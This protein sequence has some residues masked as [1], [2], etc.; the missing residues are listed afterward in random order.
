MEKEI[1]ITWHNDMGMRN[2]AR[3][4]I[5]NPTPEIRSICE[6]TGPRPIGIP[7]EWGNVLAYHY[8]GDI[9]PIIEAL[10]KKGYNPKLDE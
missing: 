4:W 10:K 2:S 9:L 8:N 5:E 7:T 3:I 1:T 6:C